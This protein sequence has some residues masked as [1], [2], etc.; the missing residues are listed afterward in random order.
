MLGK[1]EKQNKNDLQL[2]FYTWLTQA[3]PSPQIHSLVL[4]PFGHRGES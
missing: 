2:K 4:S 1:K 3:Y